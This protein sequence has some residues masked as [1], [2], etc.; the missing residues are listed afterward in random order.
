[1]ILFLGQGSEGIVMHLAPLADLLAGA[2]MVLLETFVM[3]STL[4]V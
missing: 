2:A 1:M 3:Q 4:E